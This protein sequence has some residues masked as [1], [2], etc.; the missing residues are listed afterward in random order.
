M[1]RLSGPAGGPVRATLL[2]GSVLLAGCFTG[3]RPTLT[4][5]PAT[6]GDTA[7][8]AVLERLQN[9]GTAAFTAEYTIAAPTGANADAVVVQHGPSRRAVT[10][11]DH[12]FVT[13][14][15][16]SRT[17]HLV[18]ASCVEGLDLAVVSDLAVT[19]DF[20]DLSPAARLRR[21]V[22]RRVGTTQGA[23]ESIAGEAATCVTIPIAETAARYCALDAGPLASLRTTDVTIELTAYRPDVDDT[24]FETPAAEEE[25]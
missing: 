14:G 12:R 3:E 15:A 9:A 18:H 24:A 19:A 13:D 7:A 11:R 8:D 4:P 21:D 20:Y 2:G 16:V 23:A 10:I 22:A 6:T 5:P 17:C 1:R 25:P